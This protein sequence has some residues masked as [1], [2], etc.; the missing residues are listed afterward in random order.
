MQEIANS[1]AD[2]VLTPRRERISDWRLMR[3]RSSTADKRGVEP[4][5]RPTKCCIQAA[6]QQLPMCKAV[7]VDSV[8]LVE[9]FYSTFGFPLLSSPGVVAAG[10]PPLSAVP[11]GASFSGS[12]NYL[13]RREFLPP[14]QGRNTMPLGTILLILLVL[15]LI[16]ALPTWGYSG[17]WGYGPSGILGVILIVVLVLVLLGKV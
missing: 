11:P 5:L 17:S 4:P 14:R 1:A 7:A 16:G 12:R 13:Q 6:R 8:I 3:E 9:D 15:V 10:L 2:N